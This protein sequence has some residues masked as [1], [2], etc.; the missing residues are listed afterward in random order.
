MVVLRLLTRVMVVTSIIVLATVGETSAQPQVAAGRNDLAA[1]RARG[2]LRVCM[3]PDYFAISYRN[4]RNGDLEGIE[5]DMARALAQRL[6]VQLRFV[7][8]NF[9]QFM[10]RLE[11]GDCEVAMMAVGITQARAARVNFSKPTMA[12][13]IYG[14]TTRENSRIRRWQDI[15]T[16]G[17]VVAVAAGTVM[18]PVMRDTLRNAQ[19]LVVRPPGTREAEVLAGRADVFMSDYPYTRRMVLMH[20][21]A[22]VI[23]PPARFGETLYGWAVAKAD[24]AWVNELNAFLADARSDGTLAR[25]A[26]RHGLGPILLP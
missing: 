21:W 7:E 3:W 18:E 2:E 25:A 23:D 5:I 19:L 26:Q 11:A 22:R 17:T 15:D 12:S 14:V 4:P 9:A 1:I 10:D 8:T 24:P 6:N 20:D 16:T 13:A